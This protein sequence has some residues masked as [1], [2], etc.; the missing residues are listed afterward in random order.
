[1][2]D[3]EE[4]KQALVAE[5]VNIE[6]ERFVRAFR[7]ATN[8]GGCKYCGANTRVGV[9]VPAKGKKPEHLKLACCGKE[10]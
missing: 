1:M 7:H 6:D 8:P 2:V 5:D 9:P 3:L 10:A 4:L